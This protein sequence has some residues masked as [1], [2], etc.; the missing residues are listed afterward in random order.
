VWFVVRM[1]GGKQINYR[2]KSRLMKRNAVI[3]EPEARWL[4]KAMHLLLMEL[5]RSKPGICM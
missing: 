1:Q 4:V 3:L 5:I 2:G